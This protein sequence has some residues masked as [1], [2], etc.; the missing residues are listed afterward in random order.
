VLCA[1]EDTGPG[2]PPEH[3]PYVKERLYRGRRDVAGAGLGLALVE[4]IL[5]LHGSRLEIESPAEDGRGTAA[6]FSLAI[7]PTGDAALGR[8]QAPAVR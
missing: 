3:L 8:A 2:I 6:R 5:R 4:E 7:A 1:V